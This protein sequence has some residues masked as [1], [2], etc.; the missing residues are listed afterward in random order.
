MGAKLPRGT[1]ERLWR[2]PDNWRGL[3]YV[4]EEDPRVVVPKRS[5]IMGWTINWAHSRA[6]MQVFLGV[7]VIVVI[8]GLAAATRSPLLELA[9]VVIVIVGTAIS[10]RSLA[11]EDRYEE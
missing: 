5:R 10:C 4:C 6:V 2:D 8:L 1:L 9:A 11:A 7:V 3:S